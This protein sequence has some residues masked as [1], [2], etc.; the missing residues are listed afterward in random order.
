MCPALPV[1]LIAACAILP[2]V[3]AQDRAG[4]PRHET[5]DYVAA[6]TAIAQKFGGSAGKVVP[7]GDSITYANQAGRWARHGVGRSPEQLDLARW[8]HAGDNDRSNG[9]WLAANDQPDNRSWTAASGITS[10]D[11]LTGGFRGLPSLAD[12]LREHKPQI[13][14]ILLGTNDLK[15]GVAPEAY[16]GN[17][18]RIY[19]ACADAGA[20][21]VVCT[22]LPTT[23]ATEERVSAYNAGLFRLAERRNLPFLDLYGE[24]V[25]RRP[26][27][28]WQG[29]LISDDGGHPTWE[30]SEG[31]AT[32][33][34][35]KRSGYLLKCFLQCAKVGEIRQK[36]RW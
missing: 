28:T 31:P 32:E 15:R 9:W 35:L 25:Q 36:M 12:I 27:G 33:D 22:V 23:W 34:N 10:G 5:W 6:V 24:F 11:Y 21:P 2:A 7:M 29:T 1:L 3:A 8:M 4:G 17:M 20:V 13:A 30:V 18:E 16:L 14:L 19:G 26:D